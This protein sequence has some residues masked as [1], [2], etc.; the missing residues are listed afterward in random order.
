MWGGTEDTSLFRVYS[1]VFMHHP[2]TNVTLPSGISHPLETLSFI[3]LLNVT[4][5]HFSFTHEYTMNT[6]SA[7]LCF[8]FFLFFSSQ[9]WCSVRDA[10]VCKPT[11]NR[12]KNIEKLKKSVY[13][14]PVSQNS[15][16]SLLLEK[17]IFFFGGGSYI[18][19]YT[20]LR[21]FEGF[22]LFGFFIL[23][24]CLLVRWFVF[25]L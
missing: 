10:T 12:L 19:F 20:F 21:T 15:A 11:R 1:P 14:K 25:S 16:F 3:L 23:S 22:A 17:T 4:Q 8:F 6:R 5:P 9:R 2:I 13:M 7:M 18:N 24:S